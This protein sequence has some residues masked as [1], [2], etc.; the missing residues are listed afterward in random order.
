MEKVTTLSYILTALVFLFLFSA[1]LSTEQKRRRQL[2][3]LAF[4]PALFFFSITALYRFQAESI[5]TREAASILLFIGIGLILPQLVSRIFVRQKIKHPVIFLQ[6]RKI[7]F[8]TIIPGVLLVFMAWIT[9]SSGGDAL[10]DVSV[11]VLFLS[12]IIFSIQMLVERDAICENGFYQGGL[13]S[14]WSNFK[15]YYWPQDKMYSD[16]SIQPLL[17]QNTL[18]ELTIE[19][20]NAF[21]TK[22]IRLTISFNEKNAVENLLSKKLVVEQDDSRA[23]TTA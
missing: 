12:F 13:L 8:I 6:K 11:V 4:I 10:W 16:P 20:K 22:R 14:D 17:D 2:Y 5:E 3:I 23:F 9:L 1:N 19:P 21:L 7:P 15:S 18:I